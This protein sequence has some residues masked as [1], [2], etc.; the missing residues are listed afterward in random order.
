MDATMILTDSDAELARSLIGFG[1][2]MIQPILCGWKPQ[3]RLIA[4]YEERKWPRRSPSL[5]DMIRHLMD[6]HG[7]HAS[8]HGADPGHS[9]PRQ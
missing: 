6:Q 4:A 9:E 1:V 7:P 3:A 2:R 8:R 5:A